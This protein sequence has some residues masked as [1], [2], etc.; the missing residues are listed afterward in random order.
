MTETQSRPGTSRLLLYIVLP[1]LMFLS[2]SSWALASPVGS[3]PDDDFHLAST[4]CGLGLREGLCEAGTTAAERKVPALIKDGAECY[5]FAPAESAACQDALPRSSSASLVDSNRVNSAGL[6]P[7]VYYAV[8]AVFATDDIEASVI[9][10]RLLNIVIFVAMWVG[11]YALLPRR[12]RS[13]LVWSWIIGIVP[14][15]MFLI[16]SNNPSSW[17]VISGGI[18]WIALVGYFE[19]RGRQRIALGMLAL[20]AAALG[21][22]ARADSALY[23]VLGAVVRVELR[24]GGASSTA[25][26][27]SCSTGVTAPT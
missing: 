9:A 10:M 13:T 12:R 18:G 6:Y 19:T 20:V 21:A 23:A 3:S 16:A 1:V 24:L 5:K 7:P 17:A 27:K 14:L 15:G 22:G 8:M 11:V 26:A 2:L 4:W 25:Q